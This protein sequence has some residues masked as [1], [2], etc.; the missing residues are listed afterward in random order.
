MYFILSGEGEFSE[1]GVEHDFQH[2]YDTCITLL[3]KESEKK[4]KHF[5]QLI[6]YFNH[7]LFPEAAEPEGGMD[8]EEMGIC[9]A[10]EEED[11]LEEGENEKQPTSPRD[12]DTE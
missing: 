9:K 11:E 8:N 5:K 12:E 10:I 7:E 4:G 6:E 2:F 1:Q 3:T